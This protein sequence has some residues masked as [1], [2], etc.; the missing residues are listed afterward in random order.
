MCQK[1]WEDLGMSCRMYLA[2]KMSNSSGGLVVSVVRVIFFV[3]GGNGF[4]ESWVSDELSCPG[5]LSLEYPDMFVRGSW[6]VLLS[7]PTKGAGC[8]ISEEGG[9]SVG[10]SHLDEVECRP[11]RMAAVRHP[12][13]MSY[14]MRRKGSRPR[15][16]GR[17]SHVALFSEHPTIYIC[18]HIK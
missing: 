17:G 9:T 13:G 4:G 16:Q 5:K 6:I 3:V 11:D 1:T 2:L 7:H 15:G 10:S 8:E 18:I 12:G 14:V